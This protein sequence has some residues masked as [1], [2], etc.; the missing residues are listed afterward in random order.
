MRRKN[1]I[2][3]PDDVKPGV[4]LTI[5]AAS[6]LSGIPE[7]TIRNYRRQQGIGLKFYRVGSRIFL[8]CDEF[9]AWLNLVAVEVSVRRFTFSSESK[10]RAK[11][12]P[13]S[14]VASLSY[15]NP[16]PRLHQRA[17]AGNV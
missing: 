4:L 2:T 10:F 6:K 1:L 11:E 5:K 15:S 14:T 9:I 8:K 12:S 17:G 16:V 13:A 7:S 3:L